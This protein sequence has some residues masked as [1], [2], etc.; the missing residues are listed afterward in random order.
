MAETLVRIATFNT[1]LARNGPGLLLRDI[2]SEEDPQAEAVARVIAQ[3][4]PDIIALQDIDYD[5]D[6]AAVQA[7]SDRIAHH[8]LNLRYIFAL[9]PN[10]GMVTGLDLDGDGRLGRARDAQGYGE[11]AGQGGMAVLSRFPILTGKVRDFSGYLWRDTPDAQLTLKDGTPL[12]PKDVAAI[13][14]L[15]TV[16][17]WDV[18]IQVDDATLRVLTFHASPPVFDGP[19]DRNGR[20]NHDEIIFWLHYLDGRLEQAPDA[21]FVLAGDAN[22][23]PIDGEGR[24]EAIRR[25]LSDDRLRDPTPMRSGGL[26]QGEAHTGDPRL[27]T[28]DWPAP[29]PGSLRVSYVLPSAELEILDSGIVAHDT[30]TDIAE[31]SRHRLVWVDLLVK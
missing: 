25:L 16:A 30:E 29:V 15:S 6:L 7:L 28:V 3:A 5:H 17:H 14:R 20:R 21:P 12:L 1:E 26:R 31:A 8:G 10:A 13:Q 2:L 23:D 24:K 9:R 27:D 22:L 18:P 11:F 4:Q 19:E